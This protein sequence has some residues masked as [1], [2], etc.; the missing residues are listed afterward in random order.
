M[1][2]GGQGFVAIMTQRIQIDEDIMK[3]W[4]ATI[5]QQYLSRINIGDQSNAQESESAHH[6]MLDD[7]W[8]R[9]VHTP[10]PQASQ[11][12]SSFSMPTE[13]LSELDGDIEAR[14]TATAA[15]ILEERK[16]RL[17]NFPLIHLG[18]AVPNV[19]VL[20]DSTRERFN[21]E[22]EKAAF[23]GSL[24][25]KLTG[26]DSSSDPG[27]FTQQLPPRPLVIA[28]SDRCLTPQ[29]S[30]V[31]RIARYPN[32][33]GNHTRS[34]EIFH[35]TYEADI[36]EPSSPVPAFV[37]VPDSGVASRV[38]VTPT[39]RIMQGLG[40]QQSWKRTMY[41]HVCV[42]LLTSILLLALVTLAAGV[43]KSKE[44]SNLTPTSTLE[45]TLPMD[46]QST[47]FPI[48]TSPVPSPIELAA[49]PAFSIPNG[50]TNITFPDL[51]GGIVAREETPSPTTSDFVPPTRP[52]RT[53]RPTT[54][55]TFYTTTDGL[56]RLSP[57]PSVAD[58][59]TT[60]PSW[61][62]TTW[63][64]EEDVMRAYIRNLI[65]SKSIYSSVML[66]DPSSHQY[67]AYEWLVSD[68]LLTNPILP[69]IRILQRFALA[70]FFRATSGANWTTSSLWLTSI[71]ECEW[72][73]TRSTD[74]CDSSGA[75]HSL[76]VEGNG[77]S[78]TLPPELALLRL[79]KFLKR[80]PD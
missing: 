75:L 45:P 17:N 5:E 58:D 54:A 64:G 34:S 76:E 53:R 16:D 62:N 71:N 38:T 79:S 31:H 48:V 33:P 80:A 73:H 18:T 66:E 56:N 43:I 23:G 65:A 29:L 61:I 50:D 35:Y 7:S 52:P 20:D 3:R 72:F 12:D 19:V 39:G 42:F 55:P 21:E 46:H 26:D 41:K 70:T 10:S 77:L 2:C 78:G 47:P 49:K 1:G 14:S 36:Q 25:D 74:T 13:N 59:V 24:S 40:T 27:T 51:D 69:D 15:S 8:L 28:M 57:S 30:N 67:S 68:Q 22:C 63:E 37:V 32:S 9:I 6:A 44:M 11:I 60:G 4:G